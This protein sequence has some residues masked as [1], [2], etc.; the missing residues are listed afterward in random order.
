MVS[1]TFT[2]K[3]YFREKIKTIH[4]YGSSN[5]KRCLALNTLN[6]YIF[7]VILKQTKIQL[8]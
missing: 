3:Y 6:N 4:E 7:F 2:K 1:I 8:L 5:I